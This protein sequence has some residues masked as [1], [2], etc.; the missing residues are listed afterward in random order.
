MGGSGHYQ[1]A[2]TSSTFVGERALGDLFTLAYDGSACSAIGQHVST[3]AFHYHMY[4][5]DMGELRLTD[6]SGEAVWSLSGNRG[7][8]WQAV[9][10]DVFS[11]SFAFEYRR[12][13]GYRGDAAVAQVAVNCGAAPP[14]APP[15]PPP[16]PPFA[17][18][19]PSK[20]VVSSGGKWGFEVAWSLD[21]GGLGT[22]ITGGA[23]YNEAHAVPPGNCTLEMTD[24]FGDGWSGAEWSAPGW[25][26]DV[27]SLD[28]GTYGFNVSFIVAP[29]PPR[30]PPSPLSP[31]S[32]PSPPA[33]PPSPPAPPLQPG[34]RYVIS[35]S[36]LIAALN[37]AVVKRIVLRAGVYELDDSMCSDSNI[38]NSSLCVNRAVT[39]E[40][41]VPGSVVLDAKGTGRVITVLSGAS[42]QLVG[43]NITG[44]AVVG[45]KE[46]IKNGE[47]QAVDNFGVTDYSLQGGGL[48]VVKGGTADLEDCNIFDNTAKDV[49]STFEPV[50]PGGNHMLI[51]C[52]ALPWQG[53]ASVHFEPFFPLSCE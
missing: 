5:A 10:V 8:T 38:G 40:A 7:N 44:G 31:P 42:A 48:L 17:P 15:P 14:L 20:V 18:S 50:C 49:C 29:R 6:A 11:A 2:E 3:V 25:T 28:A 37:D 21:C 46:Y 23:P 9:S 16:S 53:V 45:R 32:P 24:S 41:E 4:G 47:L 13:G 43:L 36:E 51:V 30:S 12:G 35:S 33:L 34:S 22:P 39:I 19:L 27:Y 26:G 52:C 1:Y